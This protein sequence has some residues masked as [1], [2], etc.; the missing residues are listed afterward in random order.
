[1]VFFLSPLAFPKRNF[2]LFAVRALR[3]LYDLVRQYNDKSGAD[4]SQRGPGSEH[5][6]RPQR[7]QLSIGAWSFSPLHTQRLMD[8]HQHHLRGAHAFSPEKATSGSDESQR[9]GGKPQSS[10]LARRTRTAKNKFLSR[11]IY[12]ST[13]NSG[14]NTQKYRSRWT[15]FY[16]LASVREDALPFETASRISHGNTVRPI[17]RISSVFTEPCLSLGESRRSCY[18]AR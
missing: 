14:I 16:I 17:Q 3:H 1:M 6:K 4:V 8:R 13:C 9:R 11:Y 5:G 10:S 15:I 18:N 7:A 12:I 2:P